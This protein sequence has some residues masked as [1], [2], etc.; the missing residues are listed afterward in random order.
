VSFRPS[1][2]GSRFLTLLTFKVIY[3]PLVES[4]W[5]PLPCSV[6][7]YCHINMLVILSPQSNLLVAESPSGAIDPCLNDVTRLKVLV[8]FPRRHVLA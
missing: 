6:L 5:W 3:A 7:I 1:L 4:S 2:A 8:S